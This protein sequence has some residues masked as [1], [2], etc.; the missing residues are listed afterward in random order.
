MV[1][2][3]PRRFAAILFTFVACSTLGACV[4]RAGAATIQ[5][6][7]ASLEPTTL[8]LLESQANAY[9][10]TQGPYASGVWSTSMPGCWACANGGPATAVSTSYVLSGA[11][12]ASLLTMATDTINTAIATRQLPNGGFLG[13]P[14]DGQSEPIATY[15]FGVEF[16]TV[17]HLISR[18]LDPA[19][20]IR[21]QASLAAAANFLVSSGNAIWWANGNINLG[22]AEFFFLV[23]KATGDPTYLQDYNN[24]WT[25][26]LAPPQSK[27]P[28]AGLV[29]VKAPTRADGSDG[30]GYLTETGAGG[31][32]FDPEYT[33]LQ[34]DVASRLFL[35]SGDPRALRLANLEVNMLLPLVNSS[36]VLTAD[37]GTRHAGSDYQ[38]GFLS[39]AFSV[40]S[41]F[42][43]RTNLAGD[44][45][46]EIAAERK[47]FSWPQDNPVMR[48]ALGNDI[49]VQALAESMYSAGDRSLLAKRTKDRG[50]VKRHKS[51]RT[52]LSHHHHGK[53][54]REP[55]A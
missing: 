9:A 28:D 45:A 42:G 29:I 2:S 17:Y 20:R 33:S 7:V 55:R 19:T 11:K 24:E 26:L 13:P 39:S 5:A 25:F 32:G 14:G 40:L 23:W 22:Y 10:T 37:N 4:G 27:F 38:T 15:F 53:R 41:L 51:T 16:G 48:R 46:S 52:K 18:Y 35:L 43:G 34:L 44:A 31:T 6:S 8:S 12:N 21:W 49:A 30:S 36:M 50:S 1:L 47:W 54:R 3:S